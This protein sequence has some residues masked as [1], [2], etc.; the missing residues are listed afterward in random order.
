VT[1]EAAANLAK[2]KK[3]ALA[4]EAEQRLAGT[5]WLPAI[6]RPAVPVIEE[7]PPEALAAE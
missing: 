4:A 7:L 6:L 3:D 2:L 1:P 5:G